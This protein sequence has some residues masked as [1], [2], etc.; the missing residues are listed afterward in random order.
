M[1]VQHAIAG[2]PIDDAVDATATNRG[3]ERLRVG[4]GIARPRSLELHLQ[5]ETVEAGYVARDAWNVRPVAILR[6]PPDSAVRIE[7]RQADHAAARGQMVPSVQRRRS[8]QQ[9]RQ[10]RP[11]PEQIPGCRAPQPD[12]RVVAPFAVAVQPFD[13]VDRR[14]G[15]CPTQRFPGGI[16][17]R[18]D[19]ETAQPGD[20]FNDGGG[21]AA[22][23]IRRPRHVERDVVAIVGADF[24]RIE[25][26]H[27][28]R[29]MPADREDGSRRRGRSESGIEG[30]RARRR[31]RSR[32]YPLRRRIGCC[33]RGTRRRPYGWQ[34]RPRHWTR[35]VEARVGRRRRGR[36]SAGHRPRRARPV[37]SER[38]SHHQRPASAFS[39]AALSVRSQVNSGS[40]RP[41]WPNA[42]VLR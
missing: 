42:A 15:V 18:S 3:E 17:V 35:D 4:A 27:A 40:V 10:G 14:I 30:P 24:D 26:E 23:G 32:V 21:R 20:V 19:P 37:S 29:C 13:P 36:G 41:K 16:R 39:A 6:T 8:I 1:K 9:H 2:N 33:A 5:A 34:C 12:P 7:T 31:W 11:R 22:E 25:A 38:I 28:V